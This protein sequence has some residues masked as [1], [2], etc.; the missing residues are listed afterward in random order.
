MDLVRKKK[1]R[2]VDNIDFLRRAGTRGKGG[3]EAYRHAVK[4]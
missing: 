2:L 3:I 1:G 4:R